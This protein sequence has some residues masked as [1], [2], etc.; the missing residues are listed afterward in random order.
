MSGGSPVARGLDGLAVG[1]SKISWVDGE[2]GSLV[3]RGFDVRELVPGTPY[4]SVAHLLLYG[5][6]PPEDPSRQVRDALSA[7][8][9]LS[10]G[11]VR[12]VDALPAN[13]PPLDALRTLISAIG[14]G[15]YDYPPKIEDGLDLMARLPLVFARFFRRSQG[16]E[17]VPIDPRMGQ[18]ETYLHQLFGSRPEPRRVRALEGYFDLLADH[19][20]NASTFALC[21]AISTESDLVS[22]ATAAL[23]VL[24]GRRHGGAP[25]LVLDMLD[26]I[27]D[28]DHAERWI[29]DRL[30]R[31]E[32]VFGFGHRIYKVEDPRSELLHELARGVGDPARIAF[33]ER[34]E[35][36]ALAALRRRHPNARIYTNVEFYAALLLEA[37]GLPRTCFTPTFAIARTAG[38]IAHALEQSDGNRVIRP[39]VEYE[40]PAPGR[41]WP[42]E[43]P[44]RVSPTG[45]RPTA[46]S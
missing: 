42:H 29:E 14:T 9:Q 8:R 5:D 31:K 11:V 18:V 23:A 7:R 13:E 20:M 43:R 44:D 19:G 40:G 41:R 38:W 15:Q 21:I 17:P 46:V 10:P 26:A 35:S 33:A 1:R 30:D 6:P 37:V 16:L 28:P 4:E 3:Y 27:P 25:S 39:D 34:V 2:L 22:A 32:L 12:V 45:A 24:K 36:A